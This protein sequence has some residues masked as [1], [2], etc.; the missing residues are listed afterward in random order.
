LFLGICMSSALLSSPLSITY[1]IIS[2]LM[3]ISAPFPLPPVESRDWMGFFFSYRFSLLLVVWILK[4]R[5][6]KKTRDGLLSATLPRPSF[7]VNSVSLLLLSLSLSLSLIF[8]K[9]ENA[10]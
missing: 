9:G 2:L 3:C 10:Q 5:E 7:Y 4:K 8:S 1:S 6:A